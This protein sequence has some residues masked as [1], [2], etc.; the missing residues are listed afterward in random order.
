VVTLEITGRALEIS[1][2]EIGIHAL[3]RPDDFSP[4][5]DATVRTR[6]RSLRQKLAEYYAREAPGA[7]VRIELPKGSYVPR[8]LKVDPAA[9]PRF[10][11]EELSS[12]KAIPGRYRWYATLGILALGAFLG[13]VV[14]NM[15]QTLVRNRAPADPEPV[16]QEAW[17]PIARSDTP[18]LICLGTYSQLMPVPAESLR[19]TQEWYDPPGGLTGWYQEALPFTAR[20]RQSLVP[21]RASRVGDALGVAEAASFLTA[22]GV[23][24]QVQPETLTPKTSLRLRNIVLFGTPDHSPAA[25]SLLSD[26]RLP[27]QFDARTRE[28]VHRGGQRY[29]Y[30]EPTGRI[31]VAYGVLTV[32]PSYGSADAQFRTMVVSSTISAA[33]QAILEFYRSGAALRDLK[34]RI[35]SSRRKGFP[36]TYQVLIRCRTDGVALLGF[37]YVSHDVP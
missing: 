18:V 29:S 26:Y 17:G 28:F 3:G 20:F 1:E 4:L 6:A 33:S 23:P 15:V 14:L 2:Y 11:E 19:Q 21:N 31:A 10:G 35:E 22:L 12:S 7:V 36:T 27:F 24:F 13:A 34:K 37:E 32:M 30:E 16:V 9:Q 25:A 8:F 5:E